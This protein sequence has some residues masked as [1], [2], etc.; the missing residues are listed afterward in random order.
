[1]AQ[2]VTFDPPSDMLVGK[3]YNG[4]DYGVS[5]SMPEKHSKV[6]VIFVSELASF[7]SY[8]HF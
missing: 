8:L 6:G 7:F 4:I 3:I 2:C 5:I 1:M